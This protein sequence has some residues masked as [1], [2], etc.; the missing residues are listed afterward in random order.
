MQRYSQDY[1]DKNIK[2][3]N[4]SGSPLKKL[5][6][7]DLVNEEEKSHISP[8]VGSTSTVPL[9]TPQNIIPPTPPRRPEFSQR[10]PSAT[11]TYSQGIPPLLSKSTILNNN[12]DVEF[13]NKSPE[14]Y[15]NSSYAPSPTSSQNQQSFTVNRGANDPPL[16]IE[17][18]QLNTISPQVISTLAPLPKTVKKKSNSDPD[19]SIVIGLFDYSSNKEIWRIKKTLS[20]IKSLNDEISR[21]LLGTQFGVQNLLMV[22]DKSNFMI[23]TP[24]KVDLRRIELDTYFRTLFSL[25]MASIPGNYIS[26]VSYL[27]TRFISGDLVNLL[28]ES[29]LN[30]LKHGWLLM[31]RLKGLKYSWKVKYCELDVDGGVFKCENNG[32]FEVINLQNAQIGR[33]QDSGVNSSPGNSGTSPA[34]SSNSNEND[35]KTYRHAFV[36]MEAKKK[37][38]GF[39]KH[40]FCAETDNE[41]DIWVNFL[42]QAVDECN[43]NHSITTDSLAPKSIETGSLQGENSLIS[44]E[45]ND[46]LKSPAGSP[47]KGSFKTSTKDEDKELKRAKKRSFFPFSKKLVVNEFESYRQ[48]QQQQQQQEQPCTPGSDVSNIERSLESMNISSSSYQ[49][50]QSH[51]I[52]G[53]ELTQVFKL[54]SDELFDVKVPS[55]LSHCIKYLIK[56][57]AIYEEGI[58][59]LNGSSSLIK[60]LKLKFEEELV[61]NFEELE[62]I[63]DINS[64]AGLLKLWFREIPGDVIPSEVS[65]QLERIVDTGNNEERLSNWKHVMLSR[66]PEVNRN[67]IFGILKFLNMIIDQQ[68]YN[69]MSLRNLS[70]VFSPTLNI[71]NDV[72]MEMLVNYE[73]LFSDGGEVKVRGEDVNVSNF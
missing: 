9:V 71:S 12:S 45:Y 44:I 41:R 61:V 15:P 20:K 53:N 39:N 30:V 26:Q 73:Y 43:D 14:R 25:P 49:P 69:K 32:G 59:R 35:D 37:N 42:I 68:E 58:F 67:V 3:I 21:I 56:N 18:T 60:K 34:L 55:I 5:S 46:S 7:D 22:P 11:S 8:R 51:R 47:I 50:N 62:P 54:A 27:I 52:F 6:D 70:I 57:D 1:F 2:N 4:S 40:I 38:S 17:P 24:Q 48:Q 29:N 66:V 16:L 64:I 28:D 36:I 19:F 13:N 31:K 72:L 10:A 23:N 63:P 65:Y 33:Q